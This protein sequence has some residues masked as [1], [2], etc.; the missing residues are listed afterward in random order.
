MREE[1]FF[2]QGCPKNDLQLSVRVKFDMHIPH[3][4]RLVKPRMAR[5]GRIGEILIYE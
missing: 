2:P 1:V 5:I 3:A 4:A